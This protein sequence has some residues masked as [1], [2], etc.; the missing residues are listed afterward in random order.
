[1]HHDVTLLLI[2][3]YTLT[4][5]SRYVSVCQALFKANMNSIRSS[6]ASSFNEMYA[7]ISETQHMQKITHYVGYKMCMHVRTDRS[8]MPRLH[9]TVHTLHQ[10]FQTFFKWGP[11]LLVRMFYGPP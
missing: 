5:T 9:V 7:Y 3:D 11:L 6:K 8:H 1:M 4:L 10:R 2:T